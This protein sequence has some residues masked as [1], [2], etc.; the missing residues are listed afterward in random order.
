MM[1]NCLCCVMNALMKPQTN[2]YNK[3]TCE[4][5]QGEQE[6]WEE[7]DDQSLLIESTNIMA[8]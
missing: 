3:K 8:L 5:E 7:K 2:M 6:E 4:E 1:S